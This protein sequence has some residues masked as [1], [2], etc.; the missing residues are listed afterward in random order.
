MV[1]VFLI[2]LSWEPVKMDPFG[3]KS[4]LSLIWSVCLY[5]KAKIPDF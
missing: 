5:P 2:E 3:M 4:N 1:E